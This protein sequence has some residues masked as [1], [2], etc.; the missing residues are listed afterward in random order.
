MITVLAA[1]ADVRFQ[2]AIAALILRVPNVRLERILSNQ[3][4]FIAALSRSNPPVAVLD[5]SICS[6]DQLAMIDSLQREFRST[7]FV[8]LLNEPT[9]WL[10]RRA[11]AIGILGLVL[12]DELVRD[13]RSAIRNVS[14]GKPFSSRGLLP[15]PPVSEP[16]GRVPN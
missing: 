15:R 11:R 3:V 9:P 2:E 7:E 14:R 5:Q 8:L 10:A 6:G 13:L 16:A 12:K 4:E 1:T